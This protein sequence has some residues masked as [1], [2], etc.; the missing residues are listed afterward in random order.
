MKNKHK[1]LK[2]R[3]PVIA[4]LAALLVAALNVSFAA[5]ET[6]RVLTITPITTAPAFKMEFENSK[7]SYARQSKIPFGTANNIVIRS[8][9]TAL[10]SALP[11]N[12]S[13]RQNGQEVWNTQINEDSC[14][15]CE[16]EEMNVCNVEG[17]TLTG[18]KNVFTEI[19]ATG[20]SGAPIATYTYGKA[21]KVTTTT[22]GI[23]KGGTR[24]FRD[25][26]TKGGKKTARNMTN[27][28]LDKLLKE[29]DDANLDEIDVNPPT[30]G[31]SSGSCTPGQCRNIRSTGLTVTVAGRSPG[32]AEELTNMINMVGWL[33]W[34][35]G[36][37]LV[38]AK[39]AISAFPGAMQTFLNGILATESAAQGIEVYAMVEWEKCESK[40]LIWT[41]NQWVPKKKLVKLPPPS[42]GAYW[43]SSQAMNQ[44]GLQPWNPA[45]LSD[46]QHA[47]NTT[48]HIADQLKPILTASCP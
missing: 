31:D 27:A 6:T 20:I 30:G 1:C 25:S 17:P 2:C 39:G 8:K 13:A 40:G 24:V 37:R 16:D 43:S 7:K 14:D 29:L 10:F 47:A 23:T 41:S 3:L 28:E 26:P 5:T 44:A 33:K 21:P 45:H 12:V 38:F 35:P 46:P 34:A 22:T 42:G 36:T 18:G 15:Y 32:E 19:T 4:F 9:D 48:S 11:I